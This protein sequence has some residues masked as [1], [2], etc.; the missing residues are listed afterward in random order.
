MRLLT[1]HIE[2]YSSFN[3]SSGKQSSVS[4]TVGLGQLDDLDQQATRSL[5]IKESILSASTD[6]LASF[7]QVEGRRVTRNLVYCIL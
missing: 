5:V 2:K 4:E 6:H 1:T 3:H 7:Y